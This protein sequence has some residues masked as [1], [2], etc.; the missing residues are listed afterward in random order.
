MGV[1]LFTREVG[2]R[3]LWLLDRINSQAIEG[4]VLVS[5]QMFLELFL[6]LI[7]MF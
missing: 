6:I 2:F 3:L 1:L 4:C 7:F 5:G